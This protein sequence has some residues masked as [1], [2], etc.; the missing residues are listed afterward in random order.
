MM[1]F[2]VVIPTYNRADFIKRCIDSVLEQTF[3]D[4]EIVVV[5]N[6]S[7]DNT[8]EIIES[9][10]D[11]RI[12]IFQIHNNGIIAASRNKGIREAQGEWICFLDSD[13]WWRKEKLEKVYG[14]IC[15]NDCAFI[16]HKLKTFT[17]RGA[18]K[19]LMGKVHEGGNS[20]YNVLTLGNPICTSSV[21]VKKEVLVSVE[22][23]SETPELVGVEDVDCWLK[24]L[25]N[26]IKT[27]FLDEDLGYYWIGDNLSASAKQTIQL[28]HLYEKYMK[29][30]PLVIRPIALGYLKY[31]QGSIYQSLGL[32]S[33]AYSLFKV[34]IQKARFSV[35]AKALCK[36]I[37]SAIKSI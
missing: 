10:N 22:Y 18:T 30:I 21:S 2:S 9:Y 34:S 20:F 19:H 12:H 5:D 8:L 1:K 4:F 13:D 37:F 29:E 16:Y 11:A 26:G 25:Y 17:S 7:D 24:I 23:L 33:Q 32:H 6:F 27:D 36:L 3:Q 28:S 35:K 31:Q 15:C 14:H